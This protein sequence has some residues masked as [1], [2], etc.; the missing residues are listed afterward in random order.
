MS[1]ERLGGGV[2]RWLD[3]WENNV[4][5]KVINGQTIL[6]ALK[7]ERWSRE[8]GE[9]LNDQERAEALVEHC[10]QELQSGYSPD[11]PK[12]SIRAVFASLRMDPVVTGQRAGSGTH[13]V[14]KLFDERGRLLYVGMTSRGPSRL[15]EHHRKKSWFI[16][17]FDITFER[18][19][20][21]SQA[22]KHERDTI[23]RS[24]PL[25]NVQHNGRTESRAA[26][27]SEHTDRPVLRT[28]V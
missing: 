18:F 12:Q 6:D 15:V 24:A 20:T 5:G 27:Q 11:A 2:L 28:E 23:I 22:A 10:R 19:E 14:Y 17:V 25:Y 3:R 8:L 9:D 16:D 13:V 26:S 21:R 7:G 4:L 1:V